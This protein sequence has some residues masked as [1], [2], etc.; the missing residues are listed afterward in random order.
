MDE[1]H[2]IVVGFDGSKP[3]I[4]ALDVACREAAR[5]HAVLEVVRAWDSLEGRGLPW[6]VPFDVGAAQKEIEDHLADL[7]SELLEGRTQQVRSRA[8]GGDAATVLLEAATGADLLVVGARGEGGFAGLR[9][10]SVSQ[11]LLGRAPCPLFVVPDGTAT[12]A[13]TEEMPIVVGVDGSVHARRALLW[14]AAEAHTRGVP[15]LVLHGWKRPL[16]VTGTFPATYDPGQVFEKAAHRVVDDEV[17]RVAKEAAD[18]T[19]DGRAVRAGAAAT[20]ID[21]SAGASLIVVGS[22]G[23]GTFAGHLLGSVSH[24]VVRHACCPVVVVPAA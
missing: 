3:S 23:L 19:V 17:A 24:Q 16:L 1:T 10:G 18:V 11:R 14:A 21:A 7:V 13:D 8:M 12:D 22:R 4:D 2:R 5:R 9:L 20:L 15:L 6:E